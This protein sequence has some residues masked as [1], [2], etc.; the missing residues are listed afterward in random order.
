MSALII[1]IEIRQ[2]K[3]W[4]IILI[5]RWNLILNLRCNWFLAMYSSMLSNMLCK[6]AYMFV[7]PCVINYCIGL[8]SNLC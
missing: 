3:I 6:E 8:L 5:W 4:S 2:S 1:E 7:K